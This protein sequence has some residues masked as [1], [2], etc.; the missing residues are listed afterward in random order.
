MGCNGY[1]EFKQRMKEYAGQKPMEELPENLAELR[2]FFERLETK[3]FQ[4]KLEAA[5]AIAARAERVFFIGMENSGH[6]GQYGARYFTNMEKFSLFISDPF[7]PINMIDAM[8]TVARHS[9]VNL[10]YYITMQRE[11]SWTGWT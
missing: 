9:D 2:A 11:W 7:Y 1:M 4:E 3:H 6:I 5:T 8:S 10:N